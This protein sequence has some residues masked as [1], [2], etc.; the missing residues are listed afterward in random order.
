MH[1]CV[2]RC[3]AIQRWRRVLPVQRWL[4]RRRRVA[5]DG[6]VQRPMCR[7]AVL[8][9]RRDNVQS[10]QC[11]FLLWCRCVW[12]HRVL[13]RAVQYRRSRLVQP[14]PG[15]V[16]RQLHGADVVVVHGAVSEWTVLH[17]QRHVVQCM[18]RRI[19]RQQRRTDCGDVHRPVPVGSILSCGRQ[20]LQRM[21]RRLLR[22]IGGSHSGDVQWRVRGGPVLCRWLHGVQPMQ[23]RLLWCQSRIDGVHV[24]WSVPRGSVQ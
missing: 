1:C 14:V 8:C 21:H 20:W 24:Q 18:F 2:M 22:L 23:C 15:R 7:W 9:R 4:L 17:R 11:G 5:D 10:M 16:L 12:V 3:W 6:V 13:V 19:L